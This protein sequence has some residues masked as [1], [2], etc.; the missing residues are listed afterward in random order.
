MSLRPLFPRIVA[1]AVLCVGCQERKSPA[2]D[3]TD[4]ASGASVRANAAAVNARASEAFRMP[5]LIAGRLTLKDAELF[6]LACGSA[7]EPRRL[8]DA[9]GG[10]AIALM[11]GTKGAAGGV[12]ATVRLDGDRL[13]QIRYASSEGASCSNQPS[14]AT[15]DAN[16]NEPFWAVRI[17]GDL[18]TYRT[19]WELGGVVYQG[20]TWSRLDERH[21]RYEAS[22][23]GTGVT[24][25][26]LE[27][28]ETRCV[29]T[30]S[31][32]AYP[33]VAKLT[34]GDSTLTGCAAEGRGAFERTADTARGASASSR[35][36]TAG[37]LT[38]TAWRL[39]ELSGAAVVDKVQ[40]T[41]EFARGGKAA[42]SGSCNRFSGSVDVAGDSIRFGPLVTTRMACPD[43]VMRQEDLYL[44]A[45]GNA[46]RY[47]RE[48]T[49]LFIH[50]KGA[51][52]PL[53]FV[54]L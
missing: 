48:G 49:T 2:G 25:I 14:A 31:G 1:L 42:G 23:T 36:P 28:T 51:S 47:T 35:E 22:R 41:L 44:K 24:R 17:E 6:F 26:S 52:K 32:A 30:M 15:L 12:I 38:G 4:T 34:R 37:A 27:L 33:F 45:L 5:A 11:R 8:D 46:E 54:P 20:G 39:A 9:T 29:D 53:R 50:V 13:L 10:E 40:A 7:G 21:W 16:G 18:A 19:P 3:A 43:A